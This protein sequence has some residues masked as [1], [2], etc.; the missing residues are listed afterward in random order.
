MRFLKTF[1][2]LLLLLPMTGCFSNGDSSNTIYTSFY[3]VYEFTS[4]IVGDKFNVVNITPAGVEPHDFEISAKQ[5]AN[6][7]DSKAL[8]INGLGLEH[9]YNS[10]NSKI[11]SKTYEVSKDIPTRKQNNIVDPH[12]WLNP[13]YAIKEMT[14]ITSYMSEIDPDNKAYYEAN[15]LKAT[16]EF[17]TLDEYLLN[18]VATFTNKNILVNHAAFGYMCDRYGLNQIYVSGLE[19]E[20]EPSPQ[21]IAEIIKKVDEYQINT[22]F[23]EELASSEVSEAIARQCNIKTDTL[24]PLEGLKKE[25]LENGDN[26]IAVM[27]DNFKRLKKACSGE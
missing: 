17:T 14:N 15:L 12:I 26:Y 2:P 10:L 11:T 19:P 8:F 1:I 16:N 20:E 4:R 9:W 6:L 21:V 18:E 27:K 22:I 25:Q 5:L 23:T 13:L 3:P 24:N 7:Y